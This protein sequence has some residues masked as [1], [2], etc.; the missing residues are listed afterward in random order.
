[1]DTMAWKIGDHKCRHLP[2][3]S[4]FYTHDHSLLPRL[5]PTAR[6][7]WVC[8][9]SSSDSVNSAQSANPKKKSKS[10]ATPLSMSSNIY[11]KIHKTPEKIAQKNLKTSRDGG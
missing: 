2:L 5:L 4:D 8:S 7:M 11:G 3:I 6:I 9:T 1:M 10:S